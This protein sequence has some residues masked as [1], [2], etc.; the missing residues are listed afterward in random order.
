[1]SIVEVFGMLMTAVLVLGLI[2]SLVDLLVKIHRQPKKKEPA[3]LTAL[4]PY[5]LVPEPIRRNDRYYRK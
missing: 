4:S 5:P 2:W 3:D 1:M